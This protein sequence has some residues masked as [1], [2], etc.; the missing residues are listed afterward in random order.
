MYPTFLRRLISVSV[1]QAFSIAIATA[2]A[3]SE[4]LALQGKMS[5]II[6]FVIWLLLEPVMTALWCT[7]GQYLTRTRVRCYPS[8]ER[9]GVLR[10]IWRWFLRVIGGYHSMIYAPR[11][12]N[13]RGA[14]DH[15]SGTIVVFEETIP[16]PAITS[17]V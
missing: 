2:V 4:L 8:L 14:H 7:P 13:R 9:P 1:D 17:D 12:L 15:W 10:A 6:P 11:D 16:K 3:T 5:V